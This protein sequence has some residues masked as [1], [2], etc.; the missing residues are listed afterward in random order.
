ME[1][2]TKAL[3][4]AGAVLIAIMI[5]GVGIR[6]FQS[7]QETVNSSIGKMDQIEIDT[8]N[9]E[10]L[11][12]EGNQKGSNVKQLITKVIT[13]NATNKGTYDDRVIKINYNGSGDLEEANALAEK[14]TLITNGKTY[15]VKMEYNSGGLVNK[16][17]IT[18]LSK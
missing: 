10:L 9:S 4:I 15:D 7:G 6:I 5:I 12:Y 18:D 8:F 1:N 11:A 16:I 17:T 3:M 13:L 2:A 14:R